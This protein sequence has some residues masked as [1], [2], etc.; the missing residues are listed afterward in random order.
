MTRRTVPVL[1]ALALAVTACSPRDGADPG[2][3]PTGTAAAGFDA[4][5]REV[6]RPDA[7]TGGTVRVLVPRDCDLARPAGIVDAACANLLRATH[8]QLTAFA[9]LPGRFGSVAVPDLA[10]ST[11]EVGD[12]GL[13]WSFELREGARWSDGSPV[14]S[15]DVAAG[16]RALDAARDDVAVAGIEADGPR[17]VIALREPQP[18]LS[19]LLA[20]PAAAPVRPG[21]ASGPFLVASAEPLVLRRNPAWSPDA[22]PVRLPHAERIEVATIRPATAALGAVLAGTADVSLTGTVI[23]QEGQAVLDDPALAPATDR[24]GTGAT[25]YLALPARAGTP[26]AQD[27]CRR[28][29]FSAID[30]ADAVRALGGPAVAVPMTTLSPPTI[31]SFE[32]SYEP[33]PVGEGRTG[34]VEAARSALAECGHANPALTLAH[35]GADAALAGSVAASLAEAGIAV[36]LLGIRADAYDALTSAPGR[37]DTAGIDAILVVRAPEV[38]GVGGFWLPLAQGPSNLARLAMPSLDALLASD[39]L[40]SPDADVQAE[41]GRLADRLVLDTARYVP[42]A[43]I[44]TVTVRP[45]S[46]TDIAASGAYAN[47]YDVVRLGRAG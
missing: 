37:V 25:A 41:L 44:T 16:V 18:L 21:L 34:D 15:D 14:T 10:T 47:G 11:G 9:S 4:A 2:P 24:P 31:A 38:P 27:A 40:R 39:A 13:T 46:L 5:I 32:P 1:L 28:A 19:T 33:F 8:R 35:S 17:L 12:D 30:R 20:L 36:R 26:W 3:S 42:I 45:P 29:V 22:D 43:A 7:G 6:V 23:P